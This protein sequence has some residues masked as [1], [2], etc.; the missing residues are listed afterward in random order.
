MR[1]LTISAFKLAYQLAL[2]IDYGTDFITAC[3]IKFKPGVPFDILLNKYPKRKV[4]STGKR[5]SGFL[6]R[7]LLIPFVVFLSFG[8]RY[9]ILIL[10]Y[11]A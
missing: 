4:N 9:L 10:V 5:E 1:L 6:D 2:A 7:T 11:R 3:L 8:L